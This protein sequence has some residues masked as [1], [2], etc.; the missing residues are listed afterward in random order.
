MLQWNADN[1]I[2]TQARGQELERLM[3]LNS[4]VATLIQ[5]GGDAMSRPVGTPGRVFTSQL[6]VYTSGRAAVI[7]AKRSAKAHHRLDLSVETESFDACVVDLCVDGDIFLRV[8][9][10][11]RITDSNPEPFMDWVSTRMSGGDSPDWPVLLG[12]DANIHSVAGMINRPAPVGRAW[13]AMLASLLDEAGTKCLNVRGVATWTDHLTRVTIRQQSAIDYSLFYPGPVGSAVDAA[14]WRTIG[15]GPSDHQRMLIDLIREPKATNNMPA[16]PVHDRIDPP[17]WESSPKKLLTE[18]LG[19]VDGGLESRIE[20]YTSRLADALEN[21]LIQDAGDPDRAA[22]V[23]TAMI[24]QA[25][26]GAGFLRAP[27]NSEAVI[28]LSTYG[29]NKKCHTLLASRDELEAKLATMHQSEGENERAATLSM[30]SEWERLDAELQQAI[31]LSKR[32]EWR[33]TS[34]RLSATTPVSEAFEL[35]HKLAGAKAGKASG[36]IPPLHASDGGI[37]FTDQQQS[38]VLAR[39]WEDRSSFRHPDNLNYD[40]GHLRRVESR[41]ADPSF[42]DVPHTAHPLSVEANEPFTGQELDDAVGLIR[43]TAPGRDGIHAKF[44]KWGIDLMREELLRMYNICLET[45][46]VP[47][48]WKIATIIPIPKEAKPTK[49]SHLRGISLLA[50]LGKVLEHLLKSRLTWLLLAFKCTVGAQTAYAAHRSTVH[51]LLRIV[52]AAKGSWRK[53]CHLVFVSFDISRAF[54]TVWHDG[55]LLKLKE[56]GV[57]GNLLRLF[58]SFLRERGARVRIGLAESGLFNLELGVPQGSVLGP[59]LWN[60]YFG[61]VGKAIE[62][63]SGKRVSWGAF[64]DDLGVWVE[65]PASGPSRVAAVAGLQSALDAIGEWSV[66]WRLAFDAGKTKLM[67]FGPRGTEGLLYSEVWKLLGVTL[68]MVSQMK[69]LGVWLDSGLTMAT[70]MTHVRNRAALRIGVLK[71]VSGSSWGA[72]TLTLLT[73]YQSWVRPV[74]EYASPV[75]ALSNRRQLHA[76]DVLQNEALRVVLRTPMAANLDAIHW[77]THSE[78]LAMRRIQA[79]ARLASSLD[80]LTHDCECSAAWR[81]WQHKHTNN[82]PPAR[83]TLSAQDGYTLPKNNSASPFRFLWLATELLGLRGHDP[84]PERF[85]HGDEVSHPPP[86]HPQLPPVLTSLCPQRPTEIGSAARSDTSE[87]VSRAQKS[88]NSVYKKLISSARAADK[89]LIVVHTDGSVLIDRA[90]VGGG[91]GV[92][93]TFPH[94]TVPLAEV[95]VQSLLSVDHT[96]SAPGGRW[97]DIQLME[98]GSVYRALATVN[99]RMSSIGMSPDNT[100]MAIFV[101]RLAVVQTLTSPVPSVRTYT[102]Y[103]ELRSL[104]DKEAIR[105]QKS[106]LVITLDWIPAHVGTPGNEAADSAAKQAAVACSESTTR[107]STVVCL[108]KPHFINHKI[109]RMRSRELQREKFVKS[110]EIRTAGRLK[111]ICD[112]NDFPPRPLVQVLKEVHAANKLLS[113]PPLPRAVEVTLARIRGK[114]E[115]RPSILVR[116]GVPCDGTCPY[117]GDISSYNYSHFLCDCRALAGHR[118]KLADSLTMCRPQVKMRVPQLIGFAG[119]LGLNVQRVAEAVGAFLVET[120]LTERLTVIP[121]APS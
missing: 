99:A 45:G 15:Q 19:N 55:L 23:L 75:W 18:K 100:W 22:H 3:S 85:E 16:V 9:S 40:A 73:L 117:C 90:G 17:K 68:E 64:A 95:N 32:E 49:A 56:V 12:C 63:A 89:R 82:I 109:S 83:L 76:L 14:K 13:D 102:P 52:D 120:G 96:E 6:E 108:P 44:L 74:M 50:M 7:V 87:N 93:W 78:Y 81:T 51:Q 1:T 5:E 2:Q 30:K 94:N 28:E 10:A 38:E 66:M 116:K 110:A 25:A 80:R 106:G 107:L 39:H 115:I 54:D 11:Y 60:T 33:K 72:D 104:I 29:W 37:A 43:G 24:Q 71:S 113:L 98:M 118:K 20:D 47:S 59:L 112:A 86:W 58:A 36:T 67:V 48:T 53:A 61:Y 31:I 46:T 34:S 97:A 111:E 119:V 35:I 79:A 77:D 70:H 84:F 4:T 92:A 57:V 88:T 21:G 114:A 27:S 26:E 62:D 121:Q 105:L 42:Y 91:M 65:M 101:D 41:V 69:V 8:I 103:W